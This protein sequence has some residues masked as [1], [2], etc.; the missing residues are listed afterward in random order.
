MLLFLRLTLCLIIPDKVYYLQPCK[1]SGGFILLV[2]ASSLSRSGIE[3]L[4]IKNLK[5]KNI[6]KELKDE[7]EKISQKVEEFTS[8]GS[9]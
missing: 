3:K 1:L 7:I 5:R 6:N 4:K 2:E 9:G 8:W